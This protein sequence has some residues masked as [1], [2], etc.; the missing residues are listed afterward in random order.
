MTRLV[1][2]TIALISVSFSN[3]RFHNEGD[4]FI[5]LNGKKQ[6]YI[7]KGKG[8]PTVVFITGLGVAM[9]NFAQLQEEIS[10]TSRTICYDRAGI[11]KSEA[12]DNERT[13]ENMCAE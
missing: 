4:T 1:L 6:Y 7:D 2:I 3:A 9:S 13:L 8:A 11:G 12:L 10:K 5:E